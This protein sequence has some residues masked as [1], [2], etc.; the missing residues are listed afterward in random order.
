MQLLALERNWLVGR[1]WL[2][3]Q[4][5]P[6]NKP[7]RV[8]SA[9]VRSFR[10]PDQSEGGELGLLPLLEGKCPPRDEGGEPASPLTLCDEDGLEHVFLGPALRIAELL[11]NAIDEDPANSRL[12][13]LHLHFL[14]WI[15]GRATG[16]S[17]RLESRLH[18][19]LRSRDRVLALSDFSTLSKVYGYMLSGLGQLAKRKGYEGLVLL[20]DETE[21]FS[22]L[23]LEARAKAV[24][25][26]KVLLSAALPGHGAGSI[27][28]SEVGDGGLG[29]IRR[30]PPRFGKESFVAIVL[31]AT[32][33][34]ESESFLRSTLGD[35]AVLDLSNFGRKD[36]LEMGDRILSLYLAAYSEIS[37]RALAAL[38]SKMELWLATGT[39]ASPRDFGRR[40]VDF[41]DQLRHASIDFA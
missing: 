31:A 19:W 3:P 21:L 27:D 15:E 14:D 40:V 4:E 20:L 5:A 35:D 2:D 26:F 17:E 23:S 18:R 25:V 1:A 37:R 22:D 10:Y 16:L 32:P 34:S 30:L 39:L 7:R 11:R 36:Y 33:G 29:I 28:L 9:L 8:Y 41:L 6:P 38:E 12:S 13:E 24:Q